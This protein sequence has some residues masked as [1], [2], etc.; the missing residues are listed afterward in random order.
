MRDLD[1]TFFVHSFCSE[2]PAI[3]AGGDMLAELFLQR[4][5]TDQ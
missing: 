5:E 4:R 3:A 2:L 1:L